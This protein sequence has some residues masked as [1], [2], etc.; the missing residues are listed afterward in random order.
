MS[1]SSSGPSTVRSLATGALSV[2]VLYLL[3]WIGALIAPFR[4]SHM[5]IGLFTTEVP[6]SIAAL[7]LGLP[8]A[9]AFGGL[10]GALVAVGYRWLAFLEPRA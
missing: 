9:L 2:G 8:W 10:S 6:A 5:F 1:R 7:A 3:C 4:A